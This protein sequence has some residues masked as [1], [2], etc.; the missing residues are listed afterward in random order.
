MKKINSLILLF[1]G[2]MFFACEDNLSIYN[3]ESDRI[4]FVF[5]GVYY[6]SVSRISFVYEPEEVTLDTLFI[7]MRVMGFVR[8]YDRK[9]SIE[10][11]SSEGSQAVPGVHYLPFNDPSLVDDYVVKA[12]FEMVTIPIVVLRDESLQKQEFSLT[13]KI[14]ENEYFKIGQLSDV[15]KKITISDI[16]S[17]PNKWTSTIDKYHFGPWGPVKHRFMIDVS[18][19]KIDD[20]YIDIRSVEYGFLRSAVDFFKEELIR[21]NK[22]LEAK[23]EGPLREEPKEGQIE[24][25]LVEMI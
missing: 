12:G 10:Q 18:G 6:D 24:G 16:L 3:S 11:I 2:F 17:K 20:E 15:Q 4:N 14:V 13:I 7:N 19:E 23:G 9:I 5:Q 8:D 21:V 22:E 25:D 1:I